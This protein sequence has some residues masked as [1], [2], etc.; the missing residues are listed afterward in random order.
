MKLQR[1]RLSVE[2]LEARVT[3]SANSSPGFDYARVAVDKNLGSSDVGPNHAMYGGTALEGGGTDIAEVYT[4]MADHGGNGDFLMIGSASSTS[5]NYYN[6]PVK[7]LLGTTK[8]NSISTLMVYSDFSTMSPTNQK[9]VL[10]KIVHAEAIFILGGDQ[11]TYVNLWG[12]P[13]VSGGGSFTIGGTTVRTITEAINYVASQ[14]APIGGTSAGLAVLGQY[15]YSAQATVSATSDVSLHNPYDSSVTL[16]QNFVALPG[17][18]NTIT[19]SHFNQRDRMGRLV[20][21]MARLVTPDNPSTPNV[22]EGAVTPTPARVNGI[23]IDEQTA[24]LVETLPRTGVVVGDARVVGNL[25]APDSYSRNVFLLQS[26]SG[27]T[28]SYA[29]T[30]TDKS[31]TYLGIPA[32][33]AAVAA[34]FNLNALWSDF[35]GFV[36]PAGFTSEFFLSANAG[37]LSSPSGIYGPSSVVQAS[38]PASLQVSAPALT[39]QVAVAPTQTTSAPVS[40]SPAKSSGSTKT[41][42]SI[43]PPTADD[44]PLAAPLVSPI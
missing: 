17:L 43:L 10:D 23:G 12:K 25:P 33:R 42:V 26:P 30:A 7:S 39:T 13:A 16:A 5:G 24:L 34:K 31:L 27:A 41:T 14:G 36:A 3:P 18:A 32:Y 22:N 8:V 4:W 1:I 44:S 35:N 29:N 6:N 15:V 9:A 11:S 20:T 2:C 38:V 21:F 40:S 19:D 37:V 28:P